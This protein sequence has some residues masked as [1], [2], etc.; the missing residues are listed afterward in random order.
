M[1]RRRFIRTSLLSGLSLATIQGKILQ[2][3]RQHQKLRY[4]IDRHVPTR[5]FDGKTSWCHARAGIV[6][7]A[8]HAGMPRVVMTLNKLRLKGMDVFESMFSLY[9]NDLGNT[10]TEPL[11][12]QNLRVRYETIN[13]QKRPVAVSDFSPQ[14]HKGSQTLLGTGHTV[15]YTPEW[16]VVRP[17]PRHISYATYDPEENQWSLW[18]KL[19]MP[20]PEKFRDAGAG[21][22]QRYDLKDGTILLPISFVPPN[23]NMKVTVCRTVFDGNTLKYLQHGDEI[24]IDDET[25]G[26]GEPSLTRFEDMFYMTIR[27]NERAYV[28]RSRDGLHFEDIRPWR[29]DDGS[30]LGSYNTQ[31]HW[32]TH[33]H[34]LFL[35]YTRRGAD[36][37][38]VFRHRA[39]LFMAQVD[40]QRL[41]VLRHTERIL[42]PERGARLGNFGVTDVTADETWVTVA[43]WMKPHG[44]EKYGS[45]GSVFVAR[46]QW[47]RANELFAA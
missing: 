30:E 26:I 17:R 33:S 7:G 25:R 24:S 32:V 19:Q 41:C 12:C 21:C 40:P 14:W 27:H 35:V 4:Q 23:S 20:D 46:I 10:W 1:Q 15:V 43:E 34:G 8:G 6:P 2:G 16:K 13:R 38:H 11:P 28:T 3:C 9:S 37:D 18:N 29:F 47:N 31:Q 44:C 45:D 5:R 36:N 39:P 22:T 42:V